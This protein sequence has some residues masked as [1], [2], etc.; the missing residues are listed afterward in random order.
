VRHNDYAHRRD[1]D[2]W[3]AET[4]V[5]ANRPLGPTTLGFAYASVERNSASDPGQAFWREGLGIGVLKEVGWGLR[6][7]ITVDLARQMGDAPLAPFGKTRREWLLQAS[8]SIY[9]R[10]WNLGGFAPSLSL[11]VTRN[12]STLSLYDEKRV[13]GEVRLTKAF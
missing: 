5:L 11:T 8:V 10:D 13:R 1:I 3:D 12:F 4:R 6:P 2:G 9:K 7:Q